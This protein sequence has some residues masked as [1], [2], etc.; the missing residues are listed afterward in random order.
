MAT[1]ASFLFVPLEE[2]AAFDRALVADALL[3]EADD[4]AFVFAL[5]LLLLVVVVAWEGF[6]AVDLLVGDLLAAA[7]ALVLDDVR[8]V[9]L[10]LVDDFLLDDLVVAAADLLAAELAAP[11]LLDAMDRLRLRQYE[12]E[13]TGELYNCIRS[14]TVSTAGSSI[15][16]GARLEACFLA[17]FG[18]KMG[19]LRFFTA[20][21][22]GAAAVGAGA[23]ASG[24]A[25]AAAAAVGLSTRSMLLARYSKLSES[26][27]K[28]HTGDGGPIADR[29]VDCNVKTRPPAFWSVSKSPVSIFDCSRRV[30]AA[31]YRSRSRKIQESMLTLPGQ[32]RCCGNTEG[33]KTSARVGTR[34][35]T[36]EAVLAVG[37]KDGAGAGLPALAGR[38]N[39]Y[40][41]GTGEAGLPEPESVPADS[42]GV[43]VAAVLLLVLILLWLLLEPAS[44]GSPVAD[45]AGGCAP[46]GGG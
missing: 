3:F 33:N 25:A 21:G 41:G 45:G 12:C 40:E 24:A 13:N 29:C 1:R 11:P 35:R 28:R 9:V 26:C 16:K 8:L 38:L 4:F 17:N 15:N 5:W 27:V 42:F 18:G 6:F 22:G 46:S 36:V 14:S 44:V 23:G 30:G 7:A 2:A 34:T 43:D 37:R 39:E 10:L 31:W 19:S 20:T 32:S